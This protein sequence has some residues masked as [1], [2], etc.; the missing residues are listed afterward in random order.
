MTDGVEESRSVSVFEDD[1]RMSESDHGPSLQEELRIMENS[2]AI[3]P[4]DTKKRSVSKSTRKTV[5]KPQKKK[6]KV[7]DENTQEVI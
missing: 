3:K 2:S 4:E 6:R 7:D 1:V 5:K